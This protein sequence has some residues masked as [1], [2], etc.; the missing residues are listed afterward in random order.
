[1]TSDG[2]TPEPPSQ[3]RRCWSCGSDNPA[4][5]NF[6]TRCGRPIASPPPP[7]QPPRSVTLRDIGRLMGAYSVLPLLIL[8]AINVVIAVWGAGLVYPHMDKH[9]YLFVITPRLVN[10]AELGGWSFFAYYVL[11]AAAIAISFIWM[12]YKSVRPAKNELLGRPTKEHSPLFTIGTLFMA[13]LAFNVIFYAFVSSSGTSPTTPDFEAPELWETLY[14]FANASVWEEVV[15]RILLI[16]VP[17]LLI[18]AVRRSRR[19]ELRERKL[20]QYILGGG[21]EIGKVEAALL[22]FSSVMFGIAHVWSWDVWKIIPALAAGL[23]FGYL[24]LKLGVYASIML[25]FA[26]DFLS[27]PMELWPGNF[28]LEMAFGLLSL[29]WLVVGIPFLVYYLAK[30]FGWMTGKRIWPD[31]PFKTPTPTYSYAPPYYPPAYGY[32]GQ[33]GYRPGH[34]TAQPQSGPAYRPAPAAPLPTD[35][36]AFGY[37]CPH[38][39]NG[40]AHYED[41]KLICT[42]C[43]RA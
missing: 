29:L 18:D 22:I 8:L 27:V 31:V 20:R 19:P 21:L 35:P 24:Y 5:Y 33:Q 41:G 37:R 25:H 3:T 7:Y 26:F 17:L 4:H 32:Q 40:E 42:K 1:M 43:R 36:T 2:A 10:F 15:T 38:C 39:G 11:L 13:V 16:G 14:G 12:T 23:A 9:I 34:P 28:A 6:C 30:A